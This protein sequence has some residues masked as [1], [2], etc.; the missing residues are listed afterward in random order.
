MRQT[1]ETQD[2]E[3]PQFQL[4]ATADE[5]YDHAQILNS[6]VEGPGAIIARLTGQQWTLPA[7]NQEMPDAQPA[8]YD[9]GAGYATNPA[10]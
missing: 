7:N 8:V 4:G 10:T 5:G 2:P 3:Q 9:P 1:D 6:K